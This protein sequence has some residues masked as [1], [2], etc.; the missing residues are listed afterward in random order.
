MVFIHKEKHRLTACVLFAWLS[1]A[2]VDADGQ[3]TELGKLPDLKTIATA[4]KAQSSLMNVQIV[5][6]SLKEDKRTP[7]S[8]AWVPMQEAM[9]GNAWYDGLPGS[10]VRIQ[11]DYISRGFGSTPWIE[12]ALDVGYDGQTMREVDLRYGPP[13]RQR[14]IRRGAIV[15][16]PP[17]PS[18]NPLVTIG[19]DP[20]LPYADGTGFSVNFFQVNGQPKQSLADFFLDVAKEGSG[21]WPIQWDTVAGVKT[22][23]VT[24]LGGW[25]FWFDPSAGYALRKFIAA[26]PD[27][28]GNGSLVQELDVS[29]L[30]EAAP[31]IW[32]PVRATCVQPMIGE[33]GSYIRLTYQADKVIVNDPS[34][35]SHVFTVPIPLRCF[36]HDAINGRTFVVKSASDVDDSI[37]A[38]IALLK[39]P[40]KFAP[41]TVPS[42]AMPLRPMKADAP[43]DV[44]DTTYAVA[45]AGSLLVVL[46]LLWSIVSLWRRRT[47][48]LRR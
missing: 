36:L 16:G 34:F 11:L 26:I 19:V 39:T 31:G 24:V 38:D 27:Q 23:K 1:I 14:N 25:Y 40:N 20:L 32:F 18:T 29:E 6:F 8:A 3:S 30:A 41:A 7:G 47:N 22:V 12:E 48:R 37:K 35:D 21:G 43:G 5:H 28:T 46:L 17:D 42:A 10:K 15:A 44:F 13:G 2:A 45:I 4:L 9:H 33:F